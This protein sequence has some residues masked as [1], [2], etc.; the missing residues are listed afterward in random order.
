MLIWYYLTQ[1][2]FY[3][4][5]AIINCR[6]EWMARFRFLHW[7]Q[8]RKLIYNGIRDIFRIEH[9]ELIACSEVFSIIFSILCTYLCSYLIF[10]SPS[11]PNYIKHDIILYLYTFCVVTWIQLMITLHKKQIWQYVWWL[12]TRNFFLINTYCRRRLQWWYL[13]IKC[14]ILANSL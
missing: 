3:T 13:S 10:V 7:R 8:D 12:D 5:P 2:V 4:K 11:L 6:F 9:I 1:F 14:I